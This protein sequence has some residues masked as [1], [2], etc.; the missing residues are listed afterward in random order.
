MLFKDACYSL[1]KGDAFTQAPKR[2]VIEVDIAYPLVI[3]AIDPAAEAKLVGLN[4]AVVAGR[5]LRASDTFIPGAT[6]GDTVTAP[7]V[8][9]MLSTGQASDLSTTIRVD[10]LSP[11]TA[12]DLAT[13]GSTL[14]AKQKIVTT[15]T[16]VRTL[17][18]RTFTST[19][20]YRQQVGSIPPVT[21]VA[22]DGTGPLLV[23][24]LFRPSDV[25]V[26][27]TSAGLVPATT[28][29]PPSLWAESGGS[30][31]DHGYTP[32]PPTIAG[33][34]T[35]TV[36]AYQQQTQHSS[37]EGPYLSVIGTY[38]PSRI[39]SFSDCPRLAS[40]ATEPRRLPAPT[41]PPGQCWGTRRWC[42]T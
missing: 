15:A 1:S 35:R 11:T 39:T 5:Y 30:L 27:R 25:T 9:A 38:D 31:S 16:P 18:T 14:A 2:I 37:I 42:R 32:V 26:Q 4:S 3:A 17:T 29:N 40:T 19:S 21:T 8:P 12:N 33:T 34:S 41:R 28:S 22:G 7:T 36:T 20:L 13:T 23:E 10:L 24:T 6:H